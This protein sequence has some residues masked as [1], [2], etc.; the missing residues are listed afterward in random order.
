MMKV[1]AISDT[2]GLHEK[3]VMPSGDV[4]LVAGDITNHGALS[5]VSSFNKWLGTL[6]FKYKLVIAGNHDFCFENELASAAKDLLTNCIYLQDSGVEIDT[7][8]FWGSP[9]QPWF[10]DWAFNLHRGFEIREKWDLIPEKTDV[11]ITH[12]P[13]LGKGDQCRDGSV[14]GCAD[15]M[16]RV[17]HISP[18]YHVYGHIHE[19]YGRYEDPHTFFLNVST[20]DARY[21]PINK[22]VEFEL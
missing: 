19:G 2:H 21:R 17:T 9:W 10:Y 20:C 12:G 22:P 4:L 13:P 15:L 1:V 8:R 3:V 18:S 16:N 7:Y 6:D 5:D 11:I 14:V